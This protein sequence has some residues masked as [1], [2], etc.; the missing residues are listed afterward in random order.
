MIFGDSETFLYRSRAAAAVA[1]LALF[2]ALS[3]FAHVDVFG[4]KT[5]TATSAAPQELTETFSLSG[6]CFPSASATYTLVVTNGDASGRNR[7]SSGSIAFNGVEVVRQNDFNQQAPA[8]ERTL[9]VAATNTLRVRLNAPKD[10]TLSIVIRRHIDDTAA[11][12]V[13]LGVAE[14][15]VIGTSPFTL[16]GTGTDASGVASL[17]VNGAAVTPGAGGAFSTPVT[18]TPGPNAITVMATDCEGNPSRITRNVVLSTAPV[19]TIV[20]PAAGFATQSPEI[21]LSGTV[22]APAGIASVT[23]NGQPMTVTGANWSGTLNFAGE[24]GIREITV[25]A[26]DAE[27]RSTTGRVSVAIDRTA[28]VITGRIEPPP[29]AEG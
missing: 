21:A 27:A 23:A 1:F 16:T 22:S 3:V 9:T 6:P 5:F 4:P 10:G 7:I 13:T 25:V 11:P 20:E 18:L 19:L 26:T 8:I 15:A 12:V 28:P 29:N 24:D 14:G 17:Q 2:A